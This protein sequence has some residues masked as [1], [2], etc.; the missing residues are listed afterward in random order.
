MKN[1]I[2]ATF[3]GLVLVAAILALSFSGGR[4][5]D[6]KDISY[7][8]RAGAA[9]DCSLEAAHGEPQA[10]FHMGLNLI[11][12]NLVTMIDRVPGLFAVPS[13]G[14]RFFEKISYGIDNNITARTSSGHK[15]LWF[16]NG[17]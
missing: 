2:V 3:V 11:R 8:M 9:K 10:Q 6:P 17:G 16:W 12:T 4:E 15:L 5:H 14:K 1:T 13:L 7:W